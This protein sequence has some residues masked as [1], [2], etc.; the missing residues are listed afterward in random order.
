M[1]LLLKKGIKIKIYST[2]AGQKIS[3]KLENKTDGNINKTVTQTLT[4]AN[5]WEEITFNFSAVDLTK[6]YQRIT[7]VYDVIDGTTFYIDDIS[8]A[9]VVTLTAATLPMTF[10]TANTDYG[11]WAGFN[12][13]EYAL[14]D[15]PSKTGVNTSTK[16]AKYT[17]GGATTS[18]G[19]AYTLNANIDFTTN[20]AIKMKV[21]SPVAGKKVL[22]KLEGTPAN[23]EKEFTITAANTWQDIEFYFGPT[24]TPAYKKLVV[25][26]DNGAAGNGAVYYF[27]DITQVVGTAPPAAAAPTTAP[28]TPTTTAADVISLYSETYTAGITVT[29]WNPGWGQATTYSEETIAGNKVIKYANLNYQGTEFTSVNLSTKA[30]MHV[31]YWTPDMNDFKI[32]IIGGGET[33]VT[34]PVTTK[35]QWGSIDIPLSS[36]TAVNLTNVIQMKV[37]GSGT[38]YL[39]NIYFFGTGTPPAAAAAPITVPTAPTT[40]AANVISL[41]SNAY[42]NVASSTNPGWGE[43]VTEE[44]IAG[45]A[46]KKTP[47]FLPFALT[48]SIDITGKTKLHYDIWV[49]KKPTTG[50]GVL[51][52]L[53]NTNSSATYEATTAWSAIAEGSWVSMDI[54]LSNFSGLSTTLHQVLI[55]PV[56]DLAGGQAV[57]IDN[58]YFY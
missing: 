12:G 51:V 41:Y 37:V 50:A 24:G 35:N 17:K 5:T 58:V 40:D 39:D 38:L 30:T 47:N 26:F 36:F 20:K 56:D 49:S 31:D 14:A 48:S 6:T 1:I 34:V 10:E 46:V 23:I 11:G 53:V 8:Q 15:N 28:T 43:T 19:I 27:D 9:D 25:I 32:T 54:P 3:I 22:L 21:Y 45:N 4:A 57:Y 13:G 42:T 55:D 33:L 29:N 2:V 16:V 7:F 18:A 52:K 44:T